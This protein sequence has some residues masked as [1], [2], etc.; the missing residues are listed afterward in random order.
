MGQKKEHQLGGHVSGQAN[1]PLSRPAH[2]LP[3]IQVVEETKGNP[4]DGLADAEAERRLEEYGHNELGDASGPDPFKIFIGQV[5]NAM[6]LV[7]AHSPF[8]L[9][10]EERTYQSLSR[11]FLLWQWLS[12]SLSNLGLKGESSVP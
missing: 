1:R 4:K 5:A 11:R 6:T 8:T 10:E 3:W 9:F 12:A 2:A 7:R